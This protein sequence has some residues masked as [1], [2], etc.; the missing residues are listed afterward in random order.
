MW[1][2]EINTLRKG[3][4]GWSLTRITITFLDALAKLGQATM[5]F[6]MPVRPSVRPFA[7]NNRASIGRTFTQFNIP[8]FS[9][10]YRENSSLI[11]I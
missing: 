10:I 7:Q 6:V 8:D 4:S 11:K 9:K 1:G 3:A 2:H 5:S